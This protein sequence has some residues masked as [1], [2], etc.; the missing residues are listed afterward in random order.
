[1]VHQLIKPYLDLVKYRGRASIFLWGAFIG[2][3]VASG[4]TPPLLPTVAATLA[5][6]L[7]A[8]YAYV[9]N[10]I[11]DMDADKINSAN[12]PLASGRVSKRQAVKFVIAAAAS[13]LTITFFV[14]PMVFALA[15]FGLVLG[16]IYST[17]PLS[18]KN[19]F[20]LKQTTASLWAAIASLGGGIAAAGQITGTTLYAALLFFAYGMAFSPVADI[21]DIPGDRAAGK[22]TVAVV[23]GPGFT[24]KMGVTIILVFA[25]L[26][27]LTY[28]TFGFNFA[29]PI[30]VMALSLVAAR[31]VWP[32]ISRW[33]D[34][35][36]NARAVKKLILLHFLIQAALV[37]GAL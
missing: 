2:A 7:V 29:C 3:L 15:C 17:P 23:M 13:A 10:D 21:G 20:F 8:L 33:N 30:L 24:V 14:N 12:R 5:M 18:L 28:S 9:Y 6:Y 36:C 1:M 37:F 35:D 22:K 19:R 25:V 31:T 4:G 26:T 27:A 34:H 16:Y 11:R 32:L